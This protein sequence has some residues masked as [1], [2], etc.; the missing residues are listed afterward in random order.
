MYSHPSSRRRRRFFLWGGMFFIGGFFLLGGIVM[1]L[2]NA[3]LP[4]LLAV[5]SIAYWQ[6]V[7][8]LVLS[9]ILFGSFGRHGG[10]GPGSGYKAQQRRAWKEKWMKMNEEERE[11]FRSAWRDRCSKRP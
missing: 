5:K 2:W 9:R 1:W 8:L 7:G 6:A 3:I 4:D 11:Q 10:P